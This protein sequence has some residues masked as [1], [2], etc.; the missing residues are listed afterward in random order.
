MRTTKFF[1]EKKDKPKPSSSH[2]RPTQK[3]A[4]LTSWSP[5]KADTSIKKILR[6]LTPILSPPLKDPKERKK[7]ERGQWP[8]NLACQ[9]QAMRFPHLTEPCILP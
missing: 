9:C 5:E 6:R 7:K 4:I 3:E 2:R 1:V 8:I